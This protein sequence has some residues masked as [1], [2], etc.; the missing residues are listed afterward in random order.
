MTSIDIII[1]E[2]NPDILFVSEAEVNPNLM[3]ATIVKGYHTEVSGTIDCGLARLVVFYKR[4]RHLKRVKHAEGDRQ[5]I[6][7]L[8]TTNTRIV[9][10]Y[11]GF[12]NFVPERDPIESFFNSMSL[13]CSTP[14]D[15]IVTG[16]FNIDPNRDRNSNIGRGLFTL[17]VDFSLH[18]LVEENTRFRVINRDE[19][20]CLEESMIDLVLSSTLDLEVSN[21]SQYNSDHC[22]ILITTKERPNPKTGKVTIRDWTKLKEHNIL[23]EWA[24]LGGSQPPTLQLLN[25]NLRL[26]FHKLAPMRVVCTRSDSDI[27]NPKIE[28]IKK[29]RDRILKKV[30]KTVEGDLRNKLLIKLKELNKK[31]SNTIN[32]ESKKIFQQKAES[33]N[34]KCFWEL[35]NKLQG[36]KVRNEFM[37]SST[38]VR[39]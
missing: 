11:R 9:G 5:D 13:A 4:D 8:E 17:M 26:I 2:H 15:L 21:C 34:G 25:E 12:K 14:K 38:R 30:K 27:V 20:P 37:H 7:V 18:Q 33:P 29:K 16:D 24:K 6:I 32:Y 36:K 23:G 28:K 19:K 10:V 39:K 31:V 22:A 1:Q 3:F 35:V